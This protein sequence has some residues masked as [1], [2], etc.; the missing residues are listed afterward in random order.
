M[1]HHKGMYKPIFTVLAE[2]YA[3]AKQLLAAGD[4]AGA[5]VYTDK[6]LESCDPES[7]NTLNI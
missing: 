5:R 4:L 1:W 7:N 3:E 6:K 2:L